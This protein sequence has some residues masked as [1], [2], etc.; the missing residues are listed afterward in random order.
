MNYDAFL[1]RGRKCPLRIRI[2][3]NM[4]IQSFSETQ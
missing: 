2:E 1:Q 3:G 4:D